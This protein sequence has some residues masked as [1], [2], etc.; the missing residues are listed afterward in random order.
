MQNSYAAIHPFELEWG[1]SGIAKPGMFLNPQHLA[2]DSENNIYVTDLGNSRVQKFDDTGNYIRSWGSQGSGL[3]QFA[4]PS[5]IA[6]VDN[7]VFVVDRELNIV[8]KFDSYGNFDMQWGNFGN[9]DGEFRSPN[10][11]AI[12]D[13]NFVYVVDTGNN[14]IQKFTLD[15]EFISY[16]GQSGKKAGDFVSPIDIAVDKEGKLFVTDTGNNRINIYNEDGKF[17]RTIDSSVGGFQIFPRGIIVDESNNIYVSDQRNNRIIQF[18]QYGLSLSIFGVVGLDEGKF[19]VPK[20]V[21]V[22]NNGFLYVTDTLNH[23][24]QKFTTPIATEKLIIEK[25]MVE[26]PPIEQQEQLSEP[27]D[28]VEAKIELPLVNP[29]PNDFTK[30]LISVPG[31]V[32]I[33]ASGPL[34]PVNVGDAVASDESGI[35][36]LSNNASEE[37]P[38]GIRCNVPFGSFTPIPTLPAEVIRIRS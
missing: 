27:E 28:I 38:L 33:E 15:G 7:S 14:R 32:I 24:I 3:G 34:T 17:L 37:F 11:I 8:Q 2:V 36:S 30:P 16:F 22:D 19:Q 26:E 20:D 31:D 35:L 12:S 4:H 9:G 29:V 21:V 13:E 23:R 18:N 5:G 10:G 6:V 1:S 25:E